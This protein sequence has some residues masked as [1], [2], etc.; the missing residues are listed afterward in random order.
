MRLTGNSGMSK[1]EQMAM[2]GMVLLA[3]AFIL[4]LL[5]SCA[6]VNAGDPW[7]VVGVVFVIIC[8]ITLAPRGG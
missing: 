7:T 4:F 1:V 3:L 6:P 5:T 2:F 8:V